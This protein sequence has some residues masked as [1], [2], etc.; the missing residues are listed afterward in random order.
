MT[1]VMSQLCHKK[2]PICNKMLSFLWGGQTQLR[3]HWTSNFERTITDKWN[4]TLLPCSY[5]L[6][7]HKISIHMT[8]IG[9]AGAQW[10]AYIGILA[11]LAL[12]SKIDTAGYSVYCPASVWMKV[13]IFSVSRI[14]FTTNFVAQLDDHHTIFHHPDNKNMQCAK[15]QDY[16]TKIDQHR[17]HWYDGI[18]RCN[19]YRALMIMRRTT[20]LRCNPQ[21]DD[22]DDDDNVIKT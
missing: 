14:K 19:P 1:Y 8:F 4:T 20:W 18:K 11:C 5:V 10:L 17:R 15:S 6:S 21:V 2:L 22:D 9:D 12:V 16:M 3:Q 13:E 7:N